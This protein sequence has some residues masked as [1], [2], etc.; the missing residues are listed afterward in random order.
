MPLKV[1]E[2]RQQRYYD[3]NRYRVLHDFRLVL[4]SLR[5]RRNRTDGRA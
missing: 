5:L 1:T 3:S 4:W 2:D